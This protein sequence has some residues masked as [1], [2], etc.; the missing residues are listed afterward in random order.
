MKGTLLFILVA[1]G[2]AFMITAF[3]TASQ[4]QVLKDHSQTQSGS[5]RAGNFTN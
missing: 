5:A 4:I 3:G 1:L 2:I